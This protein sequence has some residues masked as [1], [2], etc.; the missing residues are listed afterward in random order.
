MTLQICNQ[1][2]DRHSCLSFTVGKGVMLKHNYE[3][4]TGMSGLLLFHFVVISNPMSGYCL[5]PA[6]V[7]GVQISPPHQSTDTARRGC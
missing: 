5:S 1:Q 4:Q 3:C 7:P 2:E 6:F